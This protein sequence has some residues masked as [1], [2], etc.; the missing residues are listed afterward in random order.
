[1]RKGRLAGLACYEEVK[2]EP[3]DEVKD[4]YWN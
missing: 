2:D 4:D 3:E 1:M